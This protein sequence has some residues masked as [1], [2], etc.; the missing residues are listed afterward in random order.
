[1]RA[2]GADDCDAR[3]RAAIATVFRGERARVLATTI[4][5]TNG[6]FELAEEAVQDAFAAALARWPTEGMPDEPRA[7]LISVA[8]QQGDRHD[9]PRAIEAA[10]DRRRPHAER[11]RSTRLEPTPVADDRLRLIFT[12]CHPA[13]AREAQVALTLRTL[14]GLDDRGDR[15]RVPRAAGDDGAAARAREDAR[16]ATRGIPYEVPEATELPERL[17]AVMAVIYLIFNEGY[18]A[19]AGDAWVRRDLCAEAIRL[20]RLLVELT[21]RAGGARPARADAA[22]RLAAR[23]AH[24][25]AGDLV[26]L[27][28]QDRARWDR[29]Q[30]DEALA[31]VPD[32]A[33]RRRAAPYRDAGGDRGAPRSAPT[34]RRHRLAADRGAVR[35][36]ATA[37]SRRR[38]S[39]STARS[40]SRCGTARP[41]AS[42]WSSRSPTSSPTITC[43]TP[44]APICCAGSAAPRAATRR[45]AN[46]LA[47]V[48][49]EPE[50]RFLQQRGIAATGSASG[51]R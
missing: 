12:C 30:I 33:A 8:R 45:I 34:R 51:T 40:R 11:G 23:R 47:L 32:R 6:D 44:R 49:S 16:S 20:G 4:R 38:S 5:V 19:T 1:M 29:A 35:R 48:G 39:R 43:G 7:W 24:R 17:D 18:A 26:L 28:D 46:A 31:L 22:P 9:P 50:R 36:A 37:A 21:R 42:R 41:R 15:A 14:G 25:R 2:R 27:E 10:R 13:L 3:D